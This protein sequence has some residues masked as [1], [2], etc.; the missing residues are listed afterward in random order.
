MKMNKILK[1]DTQ[2]MTITAQPGA[3]LTEV[4]DAAKEAGLFYPPDPGERTASIGGTVITNAGGMRAVRYGVTRDYVRCVE[5]VLPDGEI[6]KFS[7]NVVK[8]TTG[9]DIKDLIIGSEGTLC[10]VTEVT[11][12]VIPQPKATQSLVFVFDSIEPCIE[13]VPKL[14]Q[15]AFVPTAIEFLERELTGIV[16]RCLNK[17][18]PVQEGNCLSDC[19]VCWKF[20]RRSRDSM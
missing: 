12:K 7:S 5:A 13:T 2:N 17:P 10:I 18:F 9:Y 6:V 14:L 15:T 8:N 16:E 3:L 4:A 19:Y 11:V 20:Q 1:V